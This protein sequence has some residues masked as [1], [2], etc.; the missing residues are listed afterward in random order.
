MQ[1]VKFAKMLPKIA[2]ISHIPHYFLRKL[3]HSEYKYYVRHRYYAS[4]NKSIM[5]RIL[6]KNSLKKYV[7]PQFLYFVYDTKVYSMINI[8]L[9]STLQK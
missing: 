2:L 5:Q 6:H 9:S 7:F 4:Q 1:N 8:R 3:C